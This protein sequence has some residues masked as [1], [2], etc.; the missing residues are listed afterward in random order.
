MTEMNLVFAHNFSYSANVTSDD[1]K[2]MLKCNQKRWTDRY[3]VFLFT[4]QNFGNVLYARK[5]G[6]KRIQLISIFYD[7]ETVCM[8]VDKLSCCNCSLKLL[9]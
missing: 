5:S 1:K 9:L 8:I 3:H 7:S 6:R 4:K 2:C